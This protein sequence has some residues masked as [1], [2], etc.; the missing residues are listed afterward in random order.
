MKHFLK[1]SLSHTLSLSLSLSPS[2]PP[3][4]PLS[5]SLSLSLPLFLS[6]ISRPFLPLLVE[7]IVTVS[8]SQLSP[9]HAV[10]SICNSQFS[11]SG[12]CGI[13]VGKV[14]YVG[15]SIFCHLICCS[16]NIPSL[17]TALIFT[18]LPP[19]LPPFLISSLPPF[20]PPSLPPFLPSSVPSS[21][22]H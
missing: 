22:F 7:D 13:L 6:L 1:L 8:C 2:L 21:L 14:C 12:Q 11:C 18:S 15:G 10:G 20:L 16:S 5:L 9:W 4:L 17:G 19:S 3:S